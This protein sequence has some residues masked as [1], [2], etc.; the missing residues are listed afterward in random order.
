VPDVRPFVGLLYDP[1]VAG[2]FEALTAPPY[3]VISPTDQ[4]RYYRA[5]P[6]NAVRLILGKD[7]P[8]DDGS[9][10][11]YTRAALYLRSWRSLGV[12]APPTEPSLYPYEFRFH[13]GGRERTVRGVIAEVGVEEWGGSIIPHERTMSGPIEDRLTLLRAVLSNLSP[14]YA[15]AKGP[16]PKLGAF[17]DEVMQESSQCEVTDDSGT[18]HRLW[19]AS[20]REGSSATAALARHSLMIADGHHRYSVAQAYRREM[21]ARFGPGPWDATMMLIVDAATEEPPVLPIHRLVRQAQGSDAARHTIEGLQSAASPQ[22]PASLQPAASVQ[23]T[24]QHLTGGH[25]VRDM[26]E[27]LA[28]VRDEDV[29]IGVVRRENG[30]LTHRILTLS[31]APPT[32]CELHGQILDR[33]PAAD[34]RFVPDSVA[35]ER[36]VESGQVEVAFILPPTRVDRVWNVVRSGRKLPQKSTYFWPK[37]RTGMVIRPLDS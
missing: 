5:S 6:Y 24:D 29:T 36:A 10:N 2:P 25:A 4:D 34:L 22:P 14:V 27:V 26:A 18:R 23:P 7:E 28:T 1:A 37:P 20:G 15:V 17:L 13:L 30:T 12:L 35:A 32:V 11:K 16:V 21:G 9:K 33:L 19:V 31:G 3:D 8:G